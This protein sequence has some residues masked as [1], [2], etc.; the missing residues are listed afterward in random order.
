MKKI[1]SMFVVIMLL[2]QSVYAVPSYEITYCVTN[3]S[4]ES[5]TTE[6]PIHTVKLAE[7]SDTA[8]SY[9][10]SQYDLVDLYGIDITISNTAVK[11]EKGYYLDTLA[12]I[13]SSLPGTWLDLLLDYEDVDFV[14]DSTACESYGCVMVDSDYSKG[15]KLKLKQTITTNQANRTMLAALAHEVGHAFYHLGDHYYTYLA[16]SSTWENL[17][18]ALIQA[19]NGS[20]PGSDNASLDEYG[21]YFITTNA[22]NS[23]EEDFTD[24]FMMYLLEYAGLNEVSIKWT[25]STKTKADLI[26]EAINNLATELKTNVTYANNYM[27]YKDAKS[28]SNTEIHEDLVNDTYSMSTTKLK[29]VY[30]QDYLKRRVT[31]TS[32]SLC[33]AILAKEDLILLSNRT[34]LTMFKTMASYYWTWYVSSMSDSKTLSEDEFY[35]HLG[36]IQLLA[37]YIEDLYYNDAD[38][39][40][41]FYSSS[42]VNNR[43]LRYWITYIV[44]DD[45]EAAGIVSE[46]YEAYLTNNDYEANVSKYTDKTTLFSV[47]NL[48]Q[49]SA[50]NMNVYPSSRVTGITSTSSGFVVKGYMFEADAN[51]TSDLW[52]E[53]VFVNSSDVSSSKAYRKQVTPVYDTW[54]NKNT[55]AT[56]NGRYT[57]NYANYT[58]NVSP[59]SVNAYTTNTASTMAKGDYYILMRISN[60]ST[61]YLFPLCDT[62]LSDGTNLENTGKLPSGVSVYDTNT[63]ALMYSVN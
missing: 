27:S 10:S 53:I 6:L 62:T 11:R 46:A 24:S 17:K 44:D 18:S 30:A 12:T 48:K 23:V 22:A 20:Y 59:S 58:V 16:Q 25:V 7:Y 42:F 55:T 38:S 29:E 49:Y 35:K 31:A 19:S 56:S 45:K 1:I 15:S 33:D 41:S 2:G 47:D 34:H 21:D 26:A 61:S 54:L 3:S 40:M 36:N 63:R 39:V 52:R 14:L 51:C 8:A 43:I 13:L 50:M 4:C 37:Y 9:I 5:E 28:V 57:L 60:G 32:S